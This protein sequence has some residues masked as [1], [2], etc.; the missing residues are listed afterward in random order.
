H[1]VDA[2]CDIHLQYQMAKAILSFQDAAKSAMASGAV[3]ND[4]VNVPA[5]SD[6]MRGRFEK[7]YIDIIADMVKKM[8]DEIADTVEDN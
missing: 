2:Y 3:L 1:D 5:R 8:T 6:L 7:G 4:V